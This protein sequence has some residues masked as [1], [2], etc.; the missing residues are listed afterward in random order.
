APAWIDAAD[1]RVQSAPADYSAWRQLFGDPVL[2][3]LVRAAYPQNVTLRVAGT[4]VLQA[5][6]Q[7]ALP[8]GQLV[9]PTQ[10]ANGQFQHVQASNTI[11]NVPPHRFFDNWAGNFN[12]SWEL[13]FWG[14]VRRTIESTEDLVEA[15][16]D[17]YDNAMVTLIGDVAA[18]YVQYRIFEQ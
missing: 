13:D 16:V 14:K 7:R 5:R 10:T 6:A 17:D 18:A 2:D 12:L 15:S 11:A 8:G 9:P 1:P 3:E 4:R